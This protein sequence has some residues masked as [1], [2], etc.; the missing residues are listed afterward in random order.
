M[1][2]PSTLSKWF[3]T[4]LQVKMNQIE[5]IEQLLYYLPIIFLMNCLVYEM[6]KK[7]LIAYF[8]RAR[9]QITYDSSKSSHLGSL[10]W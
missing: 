9:V 10:I 2:V 1:L 3:K 4:V 7:Q 6:S 5:L 8:D